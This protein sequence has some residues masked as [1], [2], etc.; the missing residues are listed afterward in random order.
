MSKYYIDMVLQTG[1]EISMSQLRTEF[2][3][4]NPVSFSQYYNGTT[5]VGAVQGIPG[6]GVLS[7]SHFHGKARIPPGL[8]ATFTTANVVL[9]FGPTLAQLQAAYSGQSWASGLSLY[10]NIQ[11]YQMISVPND[12]TYLITCA[13][14]KGARNTTYNGG[15]GAVVSAKFNLLSTDALIIIC[16]QMGTEWPFTLAGAGGGGASYAVLLRGGVTT[17]LLGG[18]G[19]GGAGNYGQGG[20]GGNLGLDAPPTASAVGTGTTT[21]AGTANSQGGNASGFN[22]PNPG[23]N[24]CPAAFAGGLIGGNDT[25]NSRYGGF[26]GG[27]Q[28]TGGAAG[29]GG[30]GGG[31]RGGAVGAR[32]NPGGGGSSYYNSTHSTY[33]LNSVVHSVGTNN[34][35]GYVSVVKQQ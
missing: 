7:M 14:S 10:N 2:G 25:V 16:G 12:G 15:N 33:V 30:G 1:G 8:N 17:L 26:G 20:A 9:Q 27:G 23:P 18:A 22:A 28:A 34:G 4:T 21:P 3:G 6:N 31:W 32:Y 11:G 29:C 5:L 13:G 24:G 35:Y 19:G